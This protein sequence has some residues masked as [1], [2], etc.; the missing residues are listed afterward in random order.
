MPS[1]SG[2]IW[3]LMVDDNPEHLELC[4][5]S[6]PADEFE[7]A[8]AGTGTEAMRR[9]EANSYDVVVLDYAL[10]DF[11]GLE[12]LKRIKVRGFTVPIV[13]VSASN[14]ADLSM[15]ALRA[16]ACD[17]IVKSFRYYTNLR[18]RL[19]ENIDACSVRKR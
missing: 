3:V 11:T 1:P 13:F 5:E 14:D 9:L 19:L 17:Y 12:L 2:R 8:V 7:V 16:G 18:A 4:R 10:P 15:R 6:L